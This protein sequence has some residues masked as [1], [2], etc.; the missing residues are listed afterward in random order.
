MAGWCAGWRAPAKTQDL[1]GLDLQLKLSSGL[2]KQ[3]LCKYVFLNYA[4]GLV[5]EIQFSG[6]TQKTEKTYQNRWSVFKNR[7]FQNTNFFDSGH[8][9]WISVKRSK[10]THTIKTTQKRD[11]ISTNL[12]Y[13]WTDGMS[14]QG[15]SCIGA[16]VEKMHFATQPSSHPGSGWYNAGPKGDAQLVRMGGGWLAHF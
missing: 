16:E 14:K 5:G 12:G 13:S 6:K 7:C 10:F 1:E 11:A 8:Q 2:P 15:F 3:F 9:L 4:I